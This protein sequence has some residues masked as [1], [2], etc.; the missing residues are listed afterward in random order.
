MSALRF[1]GVLILALCAFA[2]AFLLAYAAILCGWIVYADYSGA[3]GGADGS[4]SAVAF[5]WAPI[6]GVLA[7]ALCAASLLRLGIRAK[8]EPAPTS[9]AAEPATIGAAPEMDIDKRL[10]EHGAL[11]RELQALTRSHALTVVE[12]GPQSG[13]SG[14]GFNAASERRVA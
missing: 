3:L 12:S 14:S 9:V 10:A 8:R 13:R 1:L 7:G 4:A 5:R 11:L 2:G 6:G